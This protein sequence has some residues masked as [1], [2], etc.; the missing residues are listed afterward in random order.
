MKFTAEV[1]KN[2]INEIAKN[3]SVK[4]RNSPEARKLANAKEI[5]A[6]LYIE[7]RL[8]PGDITGQAKKTE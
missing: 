1:F 6:R 4:I 5:N 8:V 7:G 3:E 2:C